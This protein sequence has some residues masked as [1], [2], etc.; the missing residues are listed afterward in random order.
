MVEVSGQA[1][2][3]TYVSSITINGR[4]QFV[5]LA[6]PRIAFAQAIALRDGANT[7]DIVVADLLGHSTRERLTVY[8]DRQGPL[9]LLDRVEVVGSPPLQRVHIDG[10]L[11][12][13]SGITRF[14][15]AGQPVPLPA[16]T[17]WEF[18]QEGDVSD[19]YLPISNW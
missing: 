17:E 6:E 2:D 16:G 19:L 10:F 4:A 11:T 12:D 7:V 5:E 13:R 3:D 14:V 18:R 1:E 15:L 9:L 8:V